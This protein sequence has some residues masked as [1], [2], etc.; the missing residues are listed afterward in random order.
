MSDDARVPVVA[1]L[2]AVAVLL[3]PRRPLLRAR[4]LGPLG[5][6]DD[7]GT[8]GSA[9][10]ADLVME[11]VAC[12]L[13]SGLSV[14][15]AL[16]AGA[17]TDAAATPEAAAARARPGADPATAAYLGEVVSR[18]RIGVPAERAWARPPPSLAGLAAAM[19]LAELSGAPA[20]AVVTRA[21]ADARATR[22][23]GV[24]QA[25]A[26][27]GVRLVLPLGLAILPGFVLLAVAPI[28]IGLASSVLSLAG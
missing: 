25:A 14:T 3:W 7:Q 20:A 11:L 23:E 24:E 28:V 1:V 27:L 8:P 2:V 13:R 4:P 26:R 21:A 12:A 9:L 6:P 19:V 15:D 18:L 16:E 10:S 17:G 22:R 5:P